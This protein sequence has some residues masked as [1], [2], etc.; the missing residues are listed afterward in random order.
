MGASDRQ[1]VRG[2]RLPPGR[3]HRGCRL[4][5]EHVRR[6][7]SEGVPA[8]IAR[9]LLGGVL[10]APRGTGRC[11]EGELPDA[12]PHA[13]ERRAPARAREGRLVHDDGAG[14]VPRVRGPGGDLRAPRAACDLATRHRQ[15]VD[16]RSRAR[17][18]GRRRGDRRHQRVRTAARRARPAALTVPG[19]GV[20]LGSRSAP[21]HAALLASE[22]SRTEISPR[23]R[24]RRA[25]G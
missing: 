5:P 13:L 17:A 24:T 20:P 21:R 2:R 11:A 15:R 22:G 1:A 9:D 14:H 10:R 16:P 25:S 7:G 3:R 19:R 4:R 8:S 12:R 18:L 23:A 6:R